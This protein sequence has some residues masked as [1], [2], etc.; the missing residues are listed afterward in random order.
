MSSVHWHS[1]KL[2]NFS[3]H[4]TVAVFSPLKKNSELM[5]IVVI[6]LG[7]HRTSAAAASKKLDSRGVID[8][9]YSINLHQTFGSQNMLLIS[10]KLLHCS[11]PFRR[12]EYI[13]LKL[14]NR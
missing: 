12:L 10:M 5:A 11:G 4:D 6:D 14:W 1:A 9:I 7:P 13:F 2:V 8:G 3:L